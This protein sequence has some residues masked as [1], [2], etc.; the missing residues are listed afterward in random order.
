MIE[1]IT[2]FV[3][4]T[5]LVVL[6]IIGA[7]CYSNVNEDAKCASLKAQGIAAVIQS[8]YMARKCIVIERIVKEGK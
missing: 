4:G 6:L 8:G 2:I 7:V 1:D 5:V 3:V